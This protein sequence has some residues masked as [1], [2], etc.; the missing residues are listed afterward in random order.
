MSLSLDS[1]ATVRL[2]L[3]FE[4]RLQKIAILGCQLMEAFLSQEDWFI[5]SDVE[6]CEK[7]NAETKWQKKE[8]LKKRKWD[9]PPRKESLKH[10]ELL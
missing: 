10:C 7:R 2:L 8:E 9:G 5:P 3:S 4:L 1:F 6:W